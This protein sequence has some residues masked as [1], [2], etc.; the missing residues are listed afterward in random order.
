[1][2]RKEILKN[3]RELEAVDVSLGVVQGDVRQKLAELR[4]Q[5]PHVPD[6]QEVELCDGSVCCPVC[7]EVLETSY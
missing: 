4:A 6:G 5:C 1:M 7:G 2:T 3:R